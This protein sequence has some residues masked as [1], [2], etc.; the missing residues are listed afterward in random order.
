MGMAIVE[1]QLTYGEML[2]IKY[3]NLKHCK[4][5]DAVYKPSKN[6]QRGYMDNGTAGQFHPTARV[7]ENKCPR[8]LN[9][10]ENKQEK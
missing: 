8:C 3:P 7:P 1:K 2:H 5:C 4:R 10:Q 6:W 9:D